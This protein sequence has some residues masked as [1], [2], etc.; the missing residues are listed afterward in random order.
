MKRK[1][2]CDPGAVLLLGLLL[3]SLTLKEIAALFTAVLVHE[4]G[5]LIALMLIG[6]PPDGIYI[7]ISGPVILYHQPEEQ[8]KV[9]FQKK[10]SVQH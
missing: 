4:A 10:G 2:R 6:A 5:H 8:W 9:I 7:T 3:F 1:V